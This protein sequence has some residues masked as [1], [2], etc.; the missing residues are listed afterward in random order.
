MA[1]YLDITGRRY[2]LLTVIKMHKKGKW[3]EYWEC[4]CDCGKE[5]IR[6]KSTLQKELSTSCGCEKY[7]KVSASSTKPRAIYV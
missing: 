1:Q 4:V 6:A 5:V 7:K 2:G 3:S